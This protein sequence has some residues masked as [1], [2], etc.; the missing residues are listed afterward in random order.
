MKQR[1][2][3]SLDELASLE[4]Q[5]KN[6]RLQNELGKQKL[7]LDIEKVFEP[8][9]NAFE[10]AANETT[11]EISKA[12]RDTTKAIE[13]KREVIRSLTDECLK[14]L[15][16]QGVMSSYLGRSSA[17]PFKPKK[18]NLDYLMILLQKQW[19]IFLLNTNIPVTLYSD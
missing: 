17:N 12:V 5:V 1:D 10:E 11:K 19:R 13:L 16:D 4:N 8:A 3:D 2:S 18:F 14:F 9:T 7:H 15:N 6:L